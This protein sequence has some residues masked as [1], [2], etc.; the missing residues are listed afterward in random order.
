MEK[1]ETQNIKDQNLK[2]ENSEPNADKEALEETKKTEEEEQLGSD[3]TEVG[4]ESYPY[5]K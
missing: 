5:F 1:E 4:I 2:D 3:A